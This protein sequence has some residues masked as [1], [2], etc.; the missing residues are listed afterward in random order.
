MGEDSELF[1]GYGDVFEFIKDYHLRY[2]SVPEASLLQSRFSDLELTNTTAPTKF[3]LEQLRNEFVE[4][5]LQQIMLRAAKA[6]EGDSAPR[7]LE[8]LTEKL[9]RLSKYTNSA[10]DLDITNLEAA[11]EH[12]NKLREASLVNNGTPGI[13]TGFKSIDS[14]YTTGMAPGHSIIVMGYTGRAKSFFAALLAVKA[15]EQGRKPMIISL[16]MSPEEQME[17]IY[18]L[19]GSGMF[20]ISDLSRGDISLDD[21]RAWGKKKISGSPQF[22][23]V[24]SEGASEITPNV[25]QGKIDLHRPDVVIL[26]YLQLMS[27]NA[28]TQGMTPRMLNLSREI[29]LLA[30]SNAI[31][32]ISI[33]AVTDED[34]DKRDSPPVLS[35]VSWSSAIEYDANIAMA[36][37]RHD[38]SNLVEVV[39]RKN[40]HGDLF[41]FYFNVDIDRGIWEEKFDI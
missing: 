25:I 3:Y 41:D 16:E 5:R 14:A 4:A 2:K 1:G 15:W 11:E 38:N 6:L 7:V 32:I 18:A 28:K 17:R 30:V 22:T 24:S 35:Q 36:V 12:F 20:K 19:M 39:G 13:P 40:R 37:H 8:K 31:P 27:D 26:D 23:V 33:T 10:R 34:G 29:K 21:F 9:A